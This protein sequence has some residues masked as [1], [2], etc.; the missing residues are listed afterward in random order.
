MEVL[1]TTSPEVSPSAPKEMPRKIRPD[2]KASNAFMA[3]LRGPCSVVRFGARCT[4]HGSRIVLWFPWKFTVH[5]NRFFAASTQGDHRYLSTHK[6]F[7]TLDIAPRVGRQL[8]VA[9]HA[10]DRSF[11][12]G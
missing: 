5:N 4:G 10:A 1:K 9:R 11:K 2:S 6:L 8:V 7:Q 3:V 12:T